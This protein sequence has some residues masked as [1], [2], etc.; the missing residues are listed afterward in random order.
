MFSLCYP[1][2]PGTHY[3]DQVVLNL[4]RLKSAGIRGVCHHAQLTNVLNPKDNKT[5]DRTKKEYFSVWRVLLPDAN[6]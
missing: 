5:V 4:Q 1:G 2:P 3:V 6:N